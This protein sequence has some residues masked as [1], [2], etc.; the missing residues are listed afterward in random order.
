VKPTTRLAL[1]L[2]EENESVTTHMFLAAGVGSRFGGR[3]HELRHLHGYT[4][5]E[6]RLKDGRRGSRYWLIARPGVLFDPDAYRTA[7]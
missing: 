7:A 6:E 1:Q 2:L 3:I 4:I 5:G